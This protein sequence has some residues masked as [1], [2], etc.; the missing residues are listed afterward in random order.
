V[1]ELEDY[2]FGRIERSYY[3]VFNHLRGAAVMGNVRRVGLRGCS[4]SRK[5]NHNLKS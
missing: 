4:G 2:E 3:L 5:N 1:D